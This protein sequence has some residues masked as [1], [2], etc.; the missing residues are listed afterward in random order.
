MRKRQ[1][2]YS[3][4]K[5]EPL[6]LQFS[7]LTSNYE[8]PAGFIYPLLASLRALVQRR[9]GK[10]SWR[11]NPRVFFDKHGKKLVRELV[12]QLDELSGDYHR[13]GRHRMAYKAIHMQAQF[14][15]RGK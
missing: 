14:A 13:L 7:D 3:R 12:D 10:D 5:N 15:L 4:L 11:V 1:G 6:K 8:L 9:H 2:V